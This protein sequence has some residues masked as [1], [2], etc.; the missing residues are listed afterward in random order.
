[1]VPYRTRSSIEHAHDSYET[2]LTSLFYKSSL[3]FQ[4][5]KEVLQKEAKDKLLFVVPAGSAVTLDY[6]TDR[7]RIY[8]DGHGKVSQAPTIG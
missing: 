7:I 5:A 8:C 4:E 1:M 2:I 3:L 6:R